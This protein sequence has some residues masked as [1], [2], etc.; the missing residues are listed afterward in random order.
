MTNYYS[1]ESVE[2]CA[3]NAFRSANDDPG[4]VS[5]KTAIFVD[6]CLPYDHDDG[7]DHIS[8]DS[9]KDTAQSML[10]S[11]LEQSFLNDLSSRVSFSG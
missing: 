10:D 4:Y 2:S 8:E 9:I 1:R 6:R 11:D 7:T 5:R 3:R